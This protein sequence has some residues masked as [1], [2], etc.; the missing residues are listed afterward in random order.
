MFAST[1]D[2][3]AGLKVAVDEVVQMDVLE[4]TELPQKMLVYVLF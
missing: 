2:D 1:Q 3:V 4:A